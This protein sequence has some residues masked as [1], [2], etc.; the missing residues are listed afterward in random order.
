M[1]I[2]P[3]TKVNFFLDKELRLPAIRRAD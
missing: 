1:K 3:E 2:E